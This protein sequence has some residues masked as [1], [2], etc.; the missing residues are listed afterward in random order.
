MQRT[1]RRLRRVKA[2]FYLPFLL[3]VFSGLA[4]AQSVTVDA[5]LSETTIYTGEQITLTVEVEGNHFK[6]IATPKLP[7]LQGLEYLSKTPSTST[8]YSFINGVSSQSYS[9]NYYLQADKAGKYTVPPITVSVDGK[10]FKTEPIKVTIIDR[11][12]A[13]RSSK[14]GNLPDIFL[15]ML[16]SD[17]HPVLGQQIVASVVLYFKNNLQVSS[18]QPMPGWKADGFWKEELDENQQPRA[19]STIINGERY[20][21][22]V[23]IK[24]ALF[25]SKQNELSLSP[26]QIQCAVS[27]N[28]GYKDPFSSFFGGFGS[29][30][31]T[32]NLQTDPVDIHVRPL[33][34]RPAD[35]KYIDAVGQFNVSR[36]ISQNTVKVGES[37]EVT[38]I[39]KGVGNIALISKPN[40]KFP[41]SFDSYQPQQNSSIN[42]NGNEVTGTKTFTDV[43]VPRKLGKFEIPATSLAFYNNNT[44][45]YQVDDLPAIP[46]T[47]IPNPNGGG[48]VAQSNAFNV[49]PITGLA[50]WTEAGYRPVLALWWVWFGLL[51]PLIVIGV[52]YWQKTYKYKMLNDSRFARSRTAF[53]KAKSLLDQASEYA[54]NDDMKSAY[55][56]L[57]QSLSGF[58]G[59]KLNLPQAGLSDEEYIRHLTNNNVDNG[60]MTKVRR[61][62]SKCS[63]IRFA[64][65][66][67]QEDFNRDARTTQEILNELR[68]AL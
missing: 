11:N 44:K 26:Y 62:L 41:D 17:S 28:S 52:G 20:N 24:Y 30:Q 18:Y 7:D 16:V 31:R 9:Y 57:H 29:N 13:A 35:A 66:T 5:T 67:S 55:S 37:V 23:L 61:I 63:T 22:A 2:I 25:P 34:P 48:A 60:A 42:R 19:T 45:K 59:D 15:R 3:L 4:K 36:K 64:P 58:I 12:K 53:D 1:G 56:C 50:S 46:V 32:I 68:K 51:L 40:F 14:Q 47:V 39:I 49:S 65:L 8:N 27:Y 54:R 6:N 10:E 38:T 43:L 21:K 33:P